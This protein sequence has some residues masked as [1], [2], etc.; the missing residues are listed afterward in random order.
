MRVVCFSPEKQTT[1]TQFEK[2]KSP[3][4]IKIFLINKKF[5]QESIV[6]NKYSQVGSAGSVSFARVAPPNPDK[7][8]TIAT[9]NQVTA[10]QLVSFKAHVC[11]LS[12]VKHVFLNTGT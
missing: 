5:D 11:H 10:D 12:A 6:I 1:F 2:S 9:I 8:I 7:C 3:A 4:K